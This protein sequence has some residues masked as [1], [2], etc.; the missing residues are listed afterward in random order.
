MRCPSHKE[1][2]IRFMESLGNR[3]RKKGRVYLTGGGSAV[4][5]GWRENTIDIDIK[6]EH[7][8]DEI[9]RA[10]ASLKNELDVNIELASPADF[11]PPLPG[12]EE[13]SIFIQNSGSLHFFH[14]DFYAQA[15]SKIER[16]HEQDL[17][18]VQAM[19]SQGLIQQETLLGLFEAIRPNLIRYPAIDE[20]EFE[21]KVQEAVQHGSRRS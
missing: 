2:I 1:K 6:P 4:L 18:D 11:I 7:D 3:I 9:F 5:F 21:K 16:G 20:N 14:Y 13:R 17:R 8:S 15:L 12:W 10:I 19:F